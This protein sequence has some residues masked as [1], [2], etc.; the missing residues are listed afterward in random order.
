MT[1]RSANSDTPRLVSVSGEVVDVLV[2]LAFGEFV[3]PELTFA[4]L[5]GGRWEDLDFAGYSGTLALDGSRLRL[6]VEVPADEFFGS[7]YKA[8]G[9]RNQSASVTLSD[10]SGI[11]AELAHMRRL[12]AKAEIDLHHWVWRKAERPTLWVG[13][14]EGRLSRLGNL[15]VAEKRGRSFRGRDGFRLDGR[16]TWYFLPTEAEHRHLVLLDP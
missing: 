2:D 7:L 15:A 9:T 16:F 6:S 5:H 8:M 3:G 14:L 1:E 10:G 4:P 13:S 12:G 11:V